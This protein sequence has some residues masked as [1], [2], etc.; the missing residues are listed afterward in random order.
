MA[1]IEISKCKGC[2]FY[3]EEINK[4]FSQKCEQ[5]ENNDIEFS[6]NS[7]DIYVY[8]GVVPKITL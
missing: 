8:T 2:R 7:N 5:K 1:K 6:S 4:C 3:I